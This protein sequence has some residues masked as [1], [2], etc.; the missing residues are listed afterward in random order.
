MGLRA[1][2]RVLGHAPSGSGAGSGAGEWPPVQ[3]IPAG[4]L[5]CVPA[6]DLIDPDRIDA[7]VL[8]A[9]GVLLLPDP[10][11]LREL[12]APFGAE[13]DDELCRWA[14]YASTRMVDHMARPDWRAVDRIVAGNLGVADEH[15]DAAGAALMTAYD[16]RPWVPIEGVAEVLRALQAA[17]YAL[18]VVSN[19]SGTMEAQLAEHEICSVTGGEHA[20][21]AVVVDSAVVGVEK[22]DPAIFG[23]ALDALGVAPE[24]CLYVGDTVFFDVQGARAA[25]LHPV[26]VDPYDLCEIPGHDHVRGLVDL[27][28]SLDALA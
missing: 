11:A 13:P 10:A 24:R 27:V 28:G 25:G 2:G 8:D 1:G 9:G 15:L 20:E 6:S 4:S 26:H 12:L 3:R 5:R 16:A 23:F 22:P 18:A 21:V 19:A 7:V 14:H 17:D